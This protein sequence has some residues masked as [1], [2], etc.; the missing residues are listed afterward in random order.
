MGINKNYYFKGV[1]IRAVNES[2]RVGFV[3]NTMIYRVAR[4]KL[5]PKPNQFNNHVKNLNSNPIYLLNW[6]PVSNPFNPFNK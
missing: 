5:K 2:C 4:D 6:L 3:S 1:I